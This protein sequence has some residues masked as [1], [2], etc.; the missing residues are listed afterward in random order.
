MSCKGL[1]GTPLKNCKALALK[2]AKEKAYSL[3]K[4]D[5]PT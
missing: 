2:K 5:T 3:L 4:K 1:K